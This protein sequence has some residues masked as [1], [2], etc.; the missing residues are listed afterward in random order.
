MFKEQKMGGV[1]GTWWIVVAA[2]AL[3]FEKIVIESEIYDTPSI[4]ILL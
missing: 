4:L 3:G 1:P 2:R